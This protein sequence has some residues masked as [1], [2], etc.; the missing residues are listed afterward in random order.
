M[1][2]CDFAGMGC[3]VTAVLGVAVALLCF[4]VRALK[5]GAPLELTDAEVRQNRE[6]FIGTNPSLHSIDFLTHKGH[7]N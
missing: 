3:L 6:L 7:I 1:K 4:R 5:K 2:N